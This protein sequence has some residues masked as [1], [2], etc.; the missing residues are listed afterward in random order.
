VKEAFADTLSEPTRDVSVEDSFDEVLRELS[1]A[2]EIWPDEPGYV[3]ADRYR[4]VAVLGSGGH[5]RVWEAEDLLT[6][7]RVAVKIL[8]ADLGAMGARIRREVASLRLLCLPGVVQ[9]LDEGTEGDRAFLVMERVL[10]AWFPGAP[11]PA[12]W[13]RIAPVALGL[14]ETLGRVHAL[15]IVHRDLKPANILVSA[16]QR[17]TI[18]DFGL[19]R[20]ESP[21]DQS[22]TDTGA[23]LGTPR[24]LAPE[25]IRGEATSRTDLYAVGLLLY[26]ALSGHVPHAADDTMQLLQARFS[27]AAPPLAEVAP[28]VPPFVAAV[29]DDLLANNPRDRPGSAGEAL[30]RLRSSPRG[31]VPASGAWEDASLRAHLTAL[32]QGAPLDEASLRS[33]FAGRDRL[34]HIPEDAARLL[35]RRTRGEPAL[36]A[37]DLSS[38]IGAGIARRDGARIAVDREVVD[39][40]EAGLLVVPLGPPP[41]APAPPEASPDASRRLALAAPCGTPER[42]YHLLAGAAEDDDLCS[43]VAAEAAHLGHALAAA[44]R[45]GLAEAAVREGLRSTSGTGA[46]LPLL[47][48]A[49]EIALEDGTPRA[50]DA[51]L[52]ELY[53][54]RPHPGSVEPLVQLVRAALALGHRTDRAFELA[55]ALPPFAAPALE[56]RR[57]AL[58]I[59]AARVLPFAQQEA[60]MEEARAWAEA[61]DDPVARGARAGWLGRMRYRQGRFAEAAD[62][63]AEA[64]AS[65]PWVTGQVSALLRSASARMEAFALDEAAETAHLAE[66]RA[67]RHRLPSHEALAEWTVRSIDY[68]RGR[69]VTPDLEL[70]EAA[71]QLRVGDTEAM[72]CLN[73]A[74]IAFRAGDLAVAADLARRAERAWAVLGEVSGGALLA[75]SLAFACGSAL[76]EE[77]VGA[78]VERALAC[79][80]P[81]LGIQALGLVARG[82][83][84]PALAPERIAALAGLVPPASW[85]QRLDVLSIREALEAV[86]RGSSSP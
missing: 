82:G 62:L 71:A 49:V 33:L 59:T 77:A 52:S 70:I 84:M 29:V 65:E 81:G 73:E 41:A 20:P 56:R 30:D 13:E 2:P 50:L 36:V 23:I 31:A 39:R 40:L 58:Q 17:P 66:D 11:T 68:R 75:A 83:R 48:L 61:T 76:P 8:G 45:L 37:R 53:R 54:R 18:L 78:L 69:A 5:G 21:L 63:H 28:A 35:H 43:E 7:A 12:P 24:Y 46:A 27:E 26:E 85:D 47:T 1:R 67:R 4:L 34:F 22:L 15:G 60:L 86:T 16:E 80:V 79:G 55:T 32:T 6:R 44:G 38:W 42:L 72:L 51:A 9:L 64:A 10:G 25:Q 57:R 3:V 74:A 14:L 19:A